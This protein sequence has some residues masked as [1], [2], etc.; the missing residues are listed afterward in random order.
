MSRLR[1]KS[2]NSNKWQLYWVES[3]GLE[4]CFVVARNV[5]SACSVEIHMNG[6]DACDVHA[7][8][9]VR[10]SPSV[11][12]AYLKENPDR[13]W[14][15]YVYGKM[16]FQKLGAQF[17]QADGRQEMLLEDVVYEI[18]EYAPC[19]ITRARSIG[20][21][22]VSELRSDPDLEGLG[23]DDEDIWDGPVIHLIT[24][25]GICVAMCQLIEYYIYN[26]FLLGISKRQKRKYETLNDLKNGWKK[27]TLG[28]MLKSIEEAW[29]IEPVLKA[30]FQLFLAHRNLLIHGITMEERFDIRTHWGREE[31]VAFLAFFDIH[32]RIVKKAFRS[33]YYASIC[34]RLHNWGRPEELTRK[35]FGRKHEKEAGIFFHFFKLKDDAI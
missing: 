1:S 34:C 26:S 3:D 17:R 14:P 28:D 20:Q 7:T 9:I 2:K 24:C 27:K 15:G 12:R 8:R 4:D 6:F 21:K 18:D 5:R 31:L 33:S 35:M 22:A 11:E 13:R 29:K 10:I 16:L 32:A 25:L 23:Y 19:A 30:N